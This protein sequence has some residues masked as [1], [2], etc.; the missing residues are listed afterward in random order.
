MA[1][2]NDWRETE[3]DETVDPRNPPN[4]VLNRTVRTY[5]LW[6]YLGPLI[7]FALV[8][9]CAF[10]YWNWRGPDSKEMLNP[11]VGTTG[12]QSP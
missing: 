3:R 8:M 6:T 10:L 7:V 11:A 4:S 12:Q 5:A 2:Q 1:Q 9:A